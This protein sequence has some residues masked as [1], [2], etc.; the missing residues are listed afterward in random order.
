MLEMTT[1]LWVTMTDNFLSGWGQA[2][3]K[4]NKL[5]LECESNEEAN[6]VEQ[7][8]RNRSEMKY[9]NI[10]ARKPSYNARHYLTSWHD[11]TDY[12]SWYKPGYFKREDRR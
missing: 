7:N 9:V 12:D 4:T 5:V 10:C 3:G 6:I 2:R 1:K 8:A 11:K